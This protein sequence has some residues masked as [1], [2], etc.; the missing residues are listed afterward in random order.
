MP[1]NEMPS[2]LALPKALTDRLR[3]CYAEP[4][5]H[6]HSQAHVDALL[7]HLAAFRNLC[8][9]PDVVE[10]AIWF[11]D[12]VY[13]THR[14]DNEARSADM[15]QAELT[16]IGWPSP[17]VER[18][19]AMVLA[20]RH[21]DAQEQDADTLFF[22]DIDLSILG[23]GSLQYQAYSDAI[24]AEYGWV[25]DAVYRQGRSRVLK[26]FLERDAIYRTPAL[27]AAW[28]AAAR[29]NLQDELERLGRDA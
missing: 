6:Y 8:S 18:V 4:Q 25:V 2:P 22:L 1:A 21:H 5:R 23:T 9:R 19:V 13:D 12:A 10:A 27:R 7:G 24:R 14:Q 11:H 16:A 26:S 28:E 29:R 17:A 20:T 3:T 15:A